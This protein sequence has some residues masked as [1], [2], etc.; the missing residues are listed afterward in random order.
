MTDM[1]IPVY[2]WIAHNAILYPDKLAMVDLGSGRQFSYG[3][4]V[5]RARQLAGYLGHEL[6]LVKGDCL[7][8]LSQNTTDIFELQFA[9]LRLGVTL[10][11]LNW[12][13]AWPELA[14]ILTEVA[15]RVLFYD[16][17]FSDV[18]RAAAATAGISLLLTMNY[19]AESDY[20]TGLS[21]AVA[22][23]DDIATGPYD[24]W[25]ILYTSGTTGRPKGVII[26]YEM[27]VFN[28]LSVSD[29]L[30][31][32]PQSKGVTFLPTFHIGGFT[33]YANSLFFAGAATYVQ[34]GFNA[35]D[36]FALHASKEIGI[37]HSGGV[38]TQ[39]HMM[40]EEPGFAAADLTHIK[41]MAVGGA[42]VP[43]SLIKNY[44]KKGVGLNNAWGM[45]ELAGMVT[46]LQTRDTASHIG[47]CGQKVMFS[48]LRLV[49][50]AGR[51]VPLG[52][53]GQIYVK[54]PMVTPGYWKNPAAT[55]DT[56][57]DGWF[58]TG[59]AAICDKFGYFT[60]VDRWKD[61]FISG[62]ENVY[63]AEVENAMQLMPCISAVA[64]IGIP[65]K[66]WG[67]VGRAFVVLGAE[68]EYISV[69]EIISHCRTQLAKYKIP[70]EVRIV[71]DLP[72]NASGKIMKSLL[73]RG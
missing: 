20:E 52:E 51:D 71:Q 68:Y 6:G 9:C 14:Y 41:I 3:Q 23:T 16:P 58:K 72:R 69:E 42:A 67:E 15:P 2:D 30:G 32:T 73:P 63:P 29:P 46:I 38:P 33:S 11:P 49:D 10:V 22:A 59:D 50:R 40:S 35:A 62:G 25:V 47:S 56:F 61:M 31:I 28:V 70:V 37:T 48:E 60:I 65:H 57:D 43:N 7:A 55:A 54:G 39:L 27:M 44:A 18:A 24:P 45:T 5:G 19:G 8:V 1:T 26:T 34:K 66:K 64:V 12:R 17:V 4:F 13:L 21:G 53:V 36:F